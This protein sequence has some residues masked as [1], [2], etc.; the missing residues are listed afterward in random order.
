MGGVSYIVLGG[1]TGPHWGFGYASGGVTDVE[2]V[3]QT[4]VYRKTVEMYPEIKNWPTLC[5][6]YVGAG[7]PFA[8]GTVDASDYDL[9]IMSRTGTK[10]LDESNVNHVS[11]GYQMLIQ[12]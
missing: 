4:P 3:K 7:L 2:A 5:V 8:C 6:V 9:E 12:V 11:I 10:I 1:D